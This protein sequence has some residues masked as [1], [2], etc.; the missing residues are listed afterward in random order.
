MNTK[1]LAFL[2]AL[3]LFPFCAEAA[4][5]IDKGIYSYA[6]GDVSGASQ[7][8]IDLQ[9]AGA[10]SQ[11]VYNTYTGSPGEN[12]ETLSV[13]NGGIV[14]GTGSTFFN[15]KYTQ[16]NGIDSDDLYLAVFGK[17]PSGFGTV[18]NAVFSLTEGVTEFSFI[19]GTI[20]DY[21]HLT[22]TNND[23]K[24]YTISGEDILGALGLNPGDVTGT[25]SQ[26][27]TLT[28]LAGIKSVVLSSCY[29]AFEVANISAVPL[30]AALALFGTALVGMGFA[31]RRKKAL[32]A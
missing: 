21:N 19:W 26:Y 22:V 9:E 25:L 28:D 8:N 14:S 10:S 30:P 17:Y 23:G 2:A 3:V 27:F 18:G 16:P 32:F 31:R 29:D 24:T 13:W 1:F 11:Y 7:G 6:I 4:T 12:L 15:H 5:I 20:D